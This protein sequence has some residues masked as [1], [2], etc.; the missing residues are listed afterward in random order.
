[1]NDIAATGRMK[2]I[3][4]F[5]SGVGGLSILR[6]LEKMAASLELPVKFVYFAD[7]AR[8]P[9]GNRSAEDISRFVEEI[10]S[11]LDS[12]CVD[13]IVMACNT[14]AAVAARRAH[15]ISSVPVHDLIKPTANF[16]ANKFKRV[17]VIATSTT[18]QKRAFSSA[19][20]QVNP[21]CQVLEIPAPDLVPLVE[22]GKLDG[23]EVEATIQKYVDQLKAFNADSLIFGCTHFPFLENAFKKLLP[24]VSFV[25]PAVHLGKE[26][27]GGGTA[28]SNSA[29]A[30]NLNFK[31]HVYFTTGS[32]D[33]FSTAAE[34][35]LGLDSGTL[36]DSICAMALE[37]IE[38]FQI[39]PIT[40]VSKTGSHA[41]PLDQALSAT[42][43]PSA[44][45]TGF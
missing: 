37:Q 30:Q 10:V 45:P 25:D 22:S 19:I 38:S 6:Y 33:A 23:Q 1:M 27:L 12:S 9:Y 41:V 29:T 26:L 17:G 39:E 28:A 44:A 21:D 14:S 3:G 42:Q 11:F 43:L 24:R 31:R 35:C 5:D 36:S 32:A 13:E 7:T 16:V 20:A 34:Q 40:E 8:C 18:C 4:L 15:E 2:R